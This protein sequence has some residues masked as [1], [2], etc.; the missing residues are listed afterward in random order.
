MCKG[1]A[2][3][4]AAIILGN[5][6]AQLA[7]KQVALAA[8]KSQLVALDKH[9]SSQDLSIKSLLRKQVR[10]HRLA[11]ITAADS[12]YVETL[13]ITHIPA[14]LQGQQDGL[15]AS[16]L[17]SLHTHFRFPSRLE[18]AAAANVDDNSGDTVQEE[19]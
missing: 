3:C 12:R 16:F 8:A 4:R 10:R 2:P 18:K 7:D 1:L 19:S 14:C 9:L 15:G 17:K 5:A 11:C 6:D 13:S